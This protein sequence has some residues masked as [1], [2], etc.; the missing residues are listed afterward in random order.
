MPKHYN[1]LYFRA[2]KPTKDSLKLILIPPYLR[3]QPCPTPFLFLK[4]LDPHLLEVELIRGMTM[5]TLSLDSMTLVL[6][7]TRHI[8]FFASAKYRAIQKATR[9][10][11]RLTSGG[12]PSAAAGP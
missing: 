3:L 10:S 6:E 2:L 5:A 1:N 9:S 8:S 4:L 11:A 7:S 12:L